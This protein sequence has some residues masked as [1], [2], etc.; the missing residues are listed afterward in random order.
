MNAATRALNP[1]LFPEGGTPAIPPARTNAGFTGKDFEKEIEQTAGVYNSRRIARLQKVDP[2]VAVIWIPDPANPGKKR[3]RVIFKRNPWLDFA[4]VWS[5]RGGRALLVEC[6]STS[7]HRLGLREGQ[8]GPEQV[9]A[10]KNWRLAGAASCVVWRFNERCVLFTPE[11]ILQAEARGDKSLVFEAGLPVAR[12]EG[13][14]R[15][16]FLATLEAAIWPKN[17]SAI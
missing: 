8:L 1:T 2:P 3:Q 7:N 6:K 17:L 12:G 4:G 10:I 14:L 11:M 5:A 13:T 16:D 15:W 9:S